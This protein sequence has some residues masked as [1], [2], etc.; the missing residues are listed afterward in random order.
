MIYETDANTAHAEMQRDMIPGT[1]T[2]LVPKY[3]YRKDN[4]V[5]VQLYIIPVSVPIF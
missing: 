4:Q 2:V 5:L 3:K 1:G